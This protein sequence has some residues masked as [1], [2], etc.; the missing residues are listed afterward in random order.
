MSE[1]RV[2]RP[3]ADD[4]RYLLGQH[5][6]GVLW[7]PVLLNL[8]E[9]RKLVLRRFLQSQAPS[10][11]GYMLTSCCNSIQLIPAAY[12]FC[13]IRFDWRVP[14]RDAKGSMRNSCSE[15]LSLRL[16]SCWTRA[17]AKS[18]IIRQVF[19]KSDRRRSPN[20][21]AVQSSD[22]DGAGG[23]AVIDITPLWSRRFF[24]LVLVPSFCAWP[25]VLG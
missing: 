13:S 16:R 3:A 8:A 24:R 23:T 5:L 19:T 6:P 25:S 2:R 11:G 14:I 17:E 9:C 15:S 12:R 18:A 7:F 20:F 1:L 10:T 4:H 22:E 21:L